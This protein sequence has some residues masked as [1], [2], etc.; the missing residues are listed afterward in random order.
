MSILNKDRTVI[1]K[2]HSLKTYPWMGKIATWQKH[3]NV[4]K[5][6]LNTMIL[7]V[8]CFHL[9]RSCPFYMGEDYYCLF[10]TH[11]SFW[12]CLK[13]SGMTLKALDQK[14]KIIHRQRISG[15]MRV[16]GK[17]GIM[18][19]LLNKDTLKSPYQGKQWQKWTLASSARLYLQ[20]KRPCLLCVATGSLYSQQRQAPSRGTVSDLF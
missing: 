1:I 16:D 13:L 20:W 19:L 11:S 9:R 8:Y 17:L 2:D 10:C 18:W 3:K 6:K 7:T 12:K 5:P 14:K 15:G 4:V